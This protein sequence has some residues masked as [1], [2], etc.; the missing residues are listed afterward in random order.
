[1]KNSKGLV[2][3]LM[4]LV[5]VLGVTSLVSAN[6]TKEGDA[7][8]GGAKGGTITVGVLLKT[9]ANPYW[10]SMKESIEKE[11]SKLPGVKVEI[12]AA[13]SEQD[14]AGQLNMLENM[15]DSGKYQ[16]L[17]VAPITPNNCISG[18]VKANK[19]GLPVVNIDEKF[20]MDALKK[21]GGYVV[22]YATSDNIKV[23]RMGAKLIVDT[24]GTSGGVCI[25]EGQA[26]ATSGEL[27]RDGAKAGFK[28]A[29]VEVLDVQPGNWDR[30]VSLDVATN[31]INKYGSKLKGIFTANDTM[32]L[33]VLQAMEN[34]GRMDICL[35]ST[36][37]NKEVQAAIDA[38]KL[39]AVVQ[40]PGGIGMAC[41]EMAV[42]AVQD[43]NPGSLNTVPETQLVPAVV[44]TPKK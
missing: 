30:Q 23:G 5:L 6:G 28:D 7:S 37:A 26:G 27:R 34:T 19:K 41:V 11:I 18:V 29:G 9:L 10:V 43:K 3:I 24:I 39:S 31:M 20:D 21:A 17:A 22:G 2:V 8:K 4:S 42:K 38:G 25:I 1:M 35:V 33:G 14:V 44:V 16:A 40:S 12:L 32:A 36:D 15:I 13:E